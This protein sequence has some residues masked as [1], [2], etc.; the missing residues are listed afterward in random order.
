MDQVISKSDKMRHRFPLQP[1][2]RTVYL[3][4]ELIM[5]SFKV[6]LLLI[7]IVA[8]SSVF[9]HEGVHYL[10]RSSTGL[11][12]RYE[13]SVKMLDF[14]PAVEFKSYA[15][16]GVTQYQVDHDSAID[17]EFLAYLVEI[18]YITGLFFV[19]L[20]NTRRYATK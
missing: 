13:M 14:G 10:Q 3:S 18:I 1:P 16:E 2:S 15:K 12:D 11:Y 4:S 6:G 17:H 8:I 7:I 5:Y 19:V 20:K 9:V